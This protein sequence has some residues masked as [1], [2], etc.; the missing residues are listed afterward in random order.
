L[1]PATFTCTA[2]IAAPCRDTPTAIRLKTTVAQAGHASSEQRAPRSLATLER[3][4][5]R[6]GWPRRWQSPAL[7][8][9]LD[10]LRYEYP[11]EIVPAGETPAAYLRRLTEEGCAT[12]PAADTPKDRA[13]VRA[14]ERELALIA[15]KHY[16]AFFLTVYDIVKFARDNGILCQGRGSAANPACYARASPKSIHVHRGAVRA[17]HI[18]RARRAPR[19]TSTSSISAARR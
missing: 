17:L 15:E 13:K 18:P 11:E 2:A 8:I 5:L 9:S 14:D 3:T 12:L 19:P 1:P 4:I 10:E 7:P 6:R 16:E